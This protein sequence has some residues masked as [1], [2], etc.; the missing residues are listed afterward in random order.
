VKARLHLKETLQVS[1]R[2]LKTSLRV[3]PQILVEECQNPHPQETLAKVQVLVILAKAV[4]HPKVTLR[5]NLQVLRTLANHL[6]LR[7]FQKVLPARIFQSLVQVKTIQK[8]RHLLKVLADPVLQAK[9]LVS[10]QVL[11][12]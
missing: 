8:A 5:V 10:L 12:T 2:V 7:V 3:L 4:L 11:K 6:R 1:L 9:T